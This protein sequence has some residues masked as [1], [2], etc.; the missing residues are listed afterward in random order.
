MGFKIR[1]SRCVPEERIQRHHRFC[2]QKTR[3]NKEICFL[4]KK[5]HK[6]HK[7]KRSFL[8]FPFN[9]HKSYIN[10]CYSTI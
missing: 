7:I 6:A 9:V 10:L 8:K 1:E 3:H 5:A 4:M 2:Q